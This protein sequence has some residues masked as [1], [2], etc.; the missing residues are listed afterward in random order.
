M[1]GRSL[2]QRILLGTVAVSAL[3]G[4]SARGQTPAPNWSATGPEA[5]RWFSHV[6]FLANDDMR[7]RE[8]GS[9][10]HRKAAE[11]VAAKFKAA[12][13]APG[14][15]GD[16]LQPVSFE[17]RR[18]IEDRSSLTLVRDGKTTPVVLGEQA[19]FGLR[20][21]PAPS[22]D[23]PLV[24]AG[25]GLQVPEIGLD[26]FAGL[27]VKGKVVVII[28]G[29][30]AGV[31]G[32]LSA[33]YQSAWV[34]AETLRRL[35]AVGL[36]SIANPRTADV[37][38]ARVSANRLA[39]AMTLADPTLGDGAG[40]QV[41]V[42]FNPAHAEQL[43]EGA[44]HT[45][46]ELLTLAESRQ[47]L[48][49][50]PLATAIQ[51]RVALETQVVQSENVVGLIKG[52]DPALA[53]EYVVLTAHLDH[54]GVGAPVNGDAIYNGAMDNAS[55]IATLIESASAIVAARPRRSVLLVAV[56]AEEKGLLGSRYFSRNPTVPRTSI[57]AN[58]NM[59]MFLPLFPLNT[60]M[61]LGLDESDLGD[62]V[63]AVAQGL[64]LGVLADPQPLRNR[65]IRSDQYSFVRDGVPAVAMKVG[66]ELGTPEAAIEAAWTKERYHAPSD[67]LQQPIDR[68]A[69]V[70][71]TDVI[72][73]L[74]VQV[75]NRPTRPAWKPD[76]FFKRFVRTTGTH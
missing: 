59:D 54:V 60:L 51:A 4:A 72:G 15:A 37:P 76:S 1:R 43:F 58:I 9:P 56:T 57:V 21:H 36:M 19:I 42:T 63:R 48:P 31:P 52:S 10:E 61:V 70:G 64:G 7:G 5:E 6:E 17:S 29:S 8:T 23:A 16:Y 65:F 44:G 73:R 2:R 18:L 47:P 50:F 13:L 22:V 33:H 30:P 38:W 53:H 75:A 11:Y 32:A 62:D 67:D 66:V 20:I 34:R 71:F 35:G 69:A 39:P 55:G 14:A 3:V 68:A 25:N 27:D 24:F 26:D 12:G 40:M 28:V 41:A 74:A 49:H 46:A 45:F